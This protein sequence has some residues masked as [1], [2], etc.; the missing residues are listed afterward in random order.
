MTAVSLAHYLS[1][2]TEALHSS[3]RGIASET[4]IVAFVSKE[5]EDG[6]G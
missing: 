5:E 2:V 1:R 6:L 4:R 3:I